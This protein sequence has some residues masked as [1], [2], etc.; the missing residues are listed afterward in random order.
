[1]VPNFLPFIKFPKIQKNYLKGVFLLN[2]SKLREKAME[3][4]IAVKVKNQKVLD[5]YIDKY[6]DF[7]FRAILR[8][9]YG[10]IDVV[11]CFFENRRSIGFTDIQFTNIKTIN[12][13]LGSLKGNN[14]FDVQIITK[15]ELDNYFEGVR[16]NSLPRLAVLK[17]TFKN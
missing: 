3:I 7:Y 6:L 9:G 2:N 15:Q 8:E 10:R 11:E 16:L 17:D 13:L 4:S 5:I 14:V 12:I 1:M